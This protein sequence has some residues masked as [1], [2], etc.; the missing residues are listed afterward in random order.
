MVT[1][2]EARAI[3]DDNLSYESQIRE[4]ECDAPYDCEN[5]SCEY[6]YPESNE[7]ESEDFEAT[8]LQRTT[9]TD[10]CLETAEEEYKSA[11]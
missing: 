9:L 4:C 11:E 7:V 6:Y 8:L 1:K 3:W 2:E 5:Y 10:I